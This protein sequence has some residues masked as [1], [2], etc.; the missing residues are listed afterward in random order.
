MSEIKLNIDGREVTGFDGQTILDIARENGVDI[1]TLCHDDRVQMYGSCGVCV[2]EAEGSPKL[3]RS[4]S[5]YA[6]NGMIIKTDTARVRKSR[7]T[8]L[9][10]LLSDHTGDCRPPCVLAC[11][12]QTDCQGY[13]GLIA[14]GEYKEALK[15]VKDKIP[16]PASIGRVCPHPCEEA[17]RR[18]L[19][20]E[21]IAIASLKQFLGDKDLETGALYTVEAGEPTGRKVAVIGGGPGG[22]TAAY[23]L[24]M[25]GHAVTVYDAMPAMGG[26][27]RYGIPEYRL[28]KK[29]LQAECAAIEGMGVAFKNNIKIGRDVSLDYL[30]ESFD[31]V[32]VAVGA[33]SS[34]GLRCKGEELEGVLGGIDFLRDVALNNPVFTG[35]KIAVV[36]GGNTAMDC[37]RT[38]VRLG[39]EKVYNIY[40]RTKNEMPA[41][42]IEIIEAE[43]EGVI[44]RNL[45]NPNE[46]NGQDGKVVSVRLQIM[47]LGEPDASGRRAPVPVEGKEET[48]EVDTVVVAIGQKLDG[49]GLEGIELTKW[50]TIAA[51]EN[52]FRTSIEGVFAIGDATNKG[53]D[54]AISAIGEAK[55]AAEMVDQYLNGEVL[56]YET[57]YLVKS[58][59]TA[60]DFADREKQ[61]RAKM[62]HRPAE[63]RRHDFLEVNLGFSEEEAKRE[64]SRCLEC[65]CHDYFECKLID[66][67]NQYKVKPEKY[68]GK[69]HNR[70]VEDDHPFIHRNPDKCILCGLCVR[71]C[72][73]VV[74]ATAL[75]LVDRGFD[76]VVKPALDIDLKNTDCIACGQCVTVCPTGALTETMMVQKQVPVREKTTETACSFCSVGCKTKMTS[77]G[78]MLIRSLPAADREKDA[79][80]CM[81]G[82]FGFG[83]IS[84]KERLSIPM[85][86][87]EKGFEEVSFEQAVVYANKKLQSLQTQYGQDC[88]AVAI[89][90]RYTNEE[91]FLAKE[92]AIKALGTG[93][94][95]S[96]SRVEGGL[97][98]V[99]GSDGSTCT[100]AE[101][102]NT[103]LIV[104]VGTD[105]MKNHPVAGMKVRRAVRG[106]AKLLILG[107]C[108]SL[109]GDVATLQM[110]AGLD[111]SLL[112]QMAKALLDSGAGKELAGYDQL[113]ASLADVVVGEKAKA[114]VDLYGQAK[115]AVI[116]FEKNTLTA[117]AAR[118]VADLALLGGHTGKPRDGVIQLLPGANAQ[119]LS[120]LGVGSGEKLRAAIDAGEIRGLF[121]FGEDVPGVDLEKLDF[122]AVQDLHMTATAGRAD[123]VFP[124]SAA[125]EVGGS[126]TSCDDAKQA[127]TP[128]VTGPVPHNGAQIAMLCN[129]AG[130]AMNYGGYKGIQAAMAKLPGAAAAPVQLAAPQGD[131]L[132]RD[133]VQS[134]NALYVS[135]MEFA[136]SRGL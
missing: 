83:E 101:L 20:E 81:K 53:A 105:L 64:A 27:L 97:A 35:R 90:D 32:I 99:L 21:P 110:D 77:T 7:Q 117:D 94:V 59:K 107:G 70:P 132:R 30:R 56:T 42:E 46:V 43:E 85:I 23:F 106:G 115:K 123:V 18:E 68:D 112:R 49:A 16:L 121:I 80:L 109:L 124:A 93:N 84:K 88:V 129:H 71:V 111:L 19:V 12:A 13:V 25:Q 108:E 135:L 114:A 75:G 14:N 5:T 50:G 57:P 24:R 63:V 98:D 22:L 52:T 78:D 66:Y 40:R 82:R 120:D 44:F 133:T 38:A 28:P 6:G 54:I 104:L 134:T 45:T 39:A 86:K 95:F 4:C 127:L 48:I 72:D 33:W 89:S 65:G 69:V 119:G 51:D 74:G 67:A 11:P 91:A 116:M 15:L 55:K 96:F 87:G 8:A 125:A 10:L 103:G 2:V 62:P 122:L 1:P 37:A 92:Y 113:A 60:E 26:M 100:L 36:G 41:E 79:L 47:E 61:P 31:A 136:H 76:T 131:A 130:T 17:C 29:L 3:L 73:E 58:E 118:L 128:A 126:F 34:T 9:E 102:E